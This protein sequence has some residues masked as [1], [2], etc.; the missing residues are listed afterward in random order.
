MRADSF[1]ED[2]L[3]SSVIEVQD[4]L[5]FFEMEALLT[6]KLLYHSCSHSQGPLAWTNN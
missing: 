5:R 3:T 6:N 4:K 2:V 1:S